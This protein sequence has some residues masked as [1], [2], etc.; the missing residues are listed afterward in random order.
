MGQCLHRWNI[1]LGWVV[2]SLS[3][4]LAIME[5]VCLGAREDINL[6][7]TPNRLGAK[8]YL[9]SEDDLYIGFDTDGAATYA[10][11]VTIAYPGSAIAY[12]YITIDNDT[13][14]K[15]RL[16]RIAISTT[17]AQLYFN[18]ILLSGEVL[19]IDARPY[20][21][22]PL[23]VTS[24][25]FGSVPNAIQPNSDLGSFFLTP[26]NSGSTNDNVITVFVEG[27]LTATL[28]YTA[29]YLSQD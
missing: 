1:H 4:G 27:S 23:S 9:D 17:G 15:R 11:N 6:F 8:F 29:S 10:G 18:Y 3:D 7:G 21:A 2:L 25:F 28:Y 26:G 22:T 5:R 14:G 20:S 19:T 12:P 13:A 24:S 16:T